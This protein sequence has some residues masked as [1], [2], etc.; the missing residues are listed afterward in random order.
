M[1][2]PGGANRAMAKRKIENP[3][4]PQNQ[5]ILNPKII[6]MQNH[7]LCENDSLLSRDPPRCDFSSLRRV[8]PSVRFNPSL[9]FGAKQV[10]RALTY[11]SQ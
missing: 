5:K 10:F 3:K 6:E 7:R 1:P 9:S 8:L 2:G 11:V 4:I